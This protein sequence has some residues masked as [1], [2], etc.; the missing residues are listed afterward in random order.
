MAILVRKGDDID[1]RIDTE[2]DPLLLVRQG[3][4]A[5]NDGELH[6]ELEQASA[7]LHVDGMERG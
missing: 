2:N 7:G 3:R 4:E 6:Q 5:K 1:T